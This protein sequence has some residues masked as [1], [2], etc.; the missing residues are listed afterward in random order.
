MRKLKELKFY[1]FVFVFILVVISLAALSTTNDEIIENEN[2]EEVFFASVDGTN[3]TSEEF[4]ILINDSKKTNQSLFANATTLVIN[5]IKN[6]DVDISFLRFFPNL[7][8]LVITNCKI[9]DINII[10]K[11][12][13]LEILQLSNNIIVNG[14][15]LDIEALKTIYI[16]NCQLKLDSI[17]TQQLNS[18]YITNME[19]DSSLTNAFLHTS[20][21]NSV[22]LDNST[23]DSINSLACFNNISTLSLKNTTVMENDYEKLCMFNKLDTI[24]LDD[25][26]DREAINFM[27]NHFKN[28]DIISSAYIVAERN[29][30]RLR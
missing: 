12:E 9:N 25:N 22:V 5:G 30:L 26:I 21:I 19:I 17:N 10:N 24:Y 6:E 1:I 13:M 7:K 15:T 14:L 18:L 27:L 29:N 28:G 20:E 3:Y 2:N 8:S 16:H 4:K 23:I 11:L